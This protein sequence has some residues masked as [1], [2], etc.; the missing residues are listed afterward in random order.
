MKRLGRLI[1]R[2]LSPQS[3]DA[4]EDEIRRAHEENLGRDIGE[5]PERAEA[6]VRLLDPYRSELGS[7]P[8]VADWGCGKQTIRRLIPSDWNYVPYDRIPRSEDTRLH[9]FN[10]GLPAEGADVIFCLGLLEYVDDFWGV[11]GA[12]IDQS[13]LCIFS[14]VGLSHDDRRVRN[15]WKWTFGEDKLVSFVESKRASCLDFTNDPRT[16]LVFIV[17][18]SSA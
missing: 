12:G 4:I 7:P 11:L 16:G 6:A 1:K 14:H 2:F 3:T 13:K 17:R 18:R 15:G 8:T 5:W 9:D 10:Q